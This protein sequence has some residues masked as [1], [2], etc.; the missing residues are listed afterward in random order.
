MDTL[1]KV[2]HLFMYIFEYVNNFV[3]FYIYN[4]ID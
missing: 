1:K 4:D 2:T 3:V